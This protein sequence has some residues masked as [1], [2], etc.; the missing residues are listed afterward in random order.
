MNL[1]IS[2]WEIVASTMLFL[3]DGG[4]D[5]TALFSQNQPYFVYACLT[6]LC[7]VGILIRFCYAIASCGDNPSQE[8]IELLSY[9]TKKKKPHEKLIS[10]FF[11]LCSLAFIIS[12]AIHGWIV[13]PIM[14]SILWGFAEVFRF[15][16]LAVIRERLK[17]IPTEQFMK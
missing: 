12:T 2:L 15:I 4:T 14:Y 3:F 8:L 10:M 16:M 11:K 7:C 17:I 1:V 13:I 9:I 6:T 5:K